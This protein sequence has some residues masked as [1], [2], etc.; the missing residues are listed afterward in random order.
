MSDSKSPID[1]LR[2]YWGF[3]E[4]REAQETIIK[5]VIEGG[6]TL[7]ILPTGGGKSVC[8]QVPAVALGGL[9]VVISPLIALMQDQVDGLNERGIRS[10]FINSHLSLQETE[11]RWNN[12]EHG[13]YRLLYL[14]PERCETELFKARASHLDVR[15]MAVDEA[16]C[17]SEWGPDF[18]PSYLRLA[19]AAE[20]LGRP[21]IIAVTATGVPSGCSVNGG[22]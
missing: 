6:D 11:R 19:E 21:P 22:G 18:R 16:H 4:F 9:T 2:K 17:I 14:A 12:A 20:L 1:I 3:E 13:Y 8:Y 10:T 5:N 15:L 7:A